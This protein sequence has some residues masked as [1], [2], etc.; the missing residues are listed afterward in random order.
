MASPRSLTKA[1]P[2]AKDMAPAK[3][4]AVYSPKLRPAVILQLWAACGSSEFNKSNAA[5]LET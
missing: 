2:S 3:V 1:T 5:K 4:N